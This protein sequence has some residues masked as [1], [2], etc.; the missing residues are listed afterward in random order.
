[1]AARKRE[2]EGE[3]RANERSRWQSQSPSSHEGGGLS[4]C[5]RGKGKTCSGGGVG[6]S[7]ILPF[8]A[9]LRRRDLKRGLVPGI[10][11][12]EA[13]F[14]ISLEERERGRVRASTA[15]EKREEA[16]KSVAPLRGRSGPARERRRKE[17]EPSPSASS[18]SKLCESGSAAKIAVGDFVAKLSDRRGRE[19][20]IHG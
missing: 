11:K 7:F 12:K 1:V 18:L 13:L 14:E 16:S 5:R 20:K 8:L 15:A 4:S 17:E 10:R 2:M 3:R 9:A 6:S 19:T